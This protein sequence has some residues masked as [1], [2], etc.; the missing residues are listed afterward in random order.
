MRAVFGVVSLLLVLAVV[1][2]LAMR[3]LKGVDPSAGAGLPAAQASAARSQAQRV[4]AEVGKLLEQGA[5]RSEAA[6]K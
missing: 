1:G 4:G 3:Q 5:A 6:D 2:I